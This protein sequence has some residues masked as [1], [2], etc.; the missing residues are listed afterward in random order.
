MINMLKA[1]FRFMDWL[2]TPAE[3]EIDYWEYY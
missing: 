1:V 3:V 2:C